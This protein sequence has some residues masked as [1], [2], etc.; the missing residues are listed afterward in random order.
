MVCVDHETNE[1]LE[2]LPRKKNEAKSPYFKRDLSLFYIKEI[3]RCGFL[4]RQRLSHFQSDV[5]CWEISLPS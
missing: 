3:L 2:Q 4:S 5:L 1:V